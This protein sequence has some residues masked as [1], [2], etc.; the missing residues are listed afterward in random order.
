MKTLDKVPIA[1]GDITVKKIGKDT[2]I[3]TE[4]SEEIHTLNETG[5]FIWFAVDGKR[6]LSKLAAMLCDEFDVPR[7]KACAELLSFINGLENKGLIKL[8]D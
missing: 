5:T 3:M 1:R 8:V 6:K 2:I 4:D 7:D